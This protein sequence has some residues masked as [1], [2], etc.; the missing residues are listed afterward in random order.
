MKNI[1]ITGAT[2]FI[3]SHLTIKLHHLGYNVRAFHRATSN[4]LTLKQVDVE[5][6]IGDIRDMDSLMRA[7][8]GCDT[9]FH[10]AA[11]VSFWKRKREE[12]LD[13]N[14]TGTRRIV[15]ACRACGV[16]KLVH[17]SSVAALGF[18]VDGKLIDE[19]TAF[20]WG[21]HIT[22]KYSKYLAEQEV[23]AGVDHV[24][25][26]TIVNPAIVIGPGD[27]YVHGGQIVRD[28]K[29]ARMPFYVDGGMNVVSVH[30]VVDGH[31]AAAARGR[32]GERYI[33]GGENLTH[34]EVFTRTARTV[35][36]RAPKLKAPVWMAAG[37]ARACDLIGDVTRKQPWITPELISGIGL[38]NWYSSDKAKR[39]LGCSSTPIDAAIREAYEW[40]GENGMM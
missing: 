12:Q 13:V 18:R 5:H 26:A 36:G 2:G 17:T 24:L 39:E 6:C 34:K 32:S 8:K 20:N 4:A 27:V 7:M 25:D 10:T 11:I 16:G 28:I 31:I 21:T 22:Y 35:G 33:L 38:Y 3:G 9:V 14:V 29:C 23:L 37:V 1:L 30:D 15:E 40:Y 19:T